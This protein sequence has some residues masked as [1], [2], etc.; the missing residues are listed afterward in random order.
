[1]T[2]NTNDCKTCQAALPD[3]LLEPG[4]RA[5]HR[6]LDAHLATCTAC[7]T[8]LEEMQATFALMDAW[9]APEPTPFFDTRV[10]A[11]LREAMAAEPEGFF[12]RMKARWMYSSNRSFKPALAGALALA[13][14]AVGGG[15]FAG[16][17][18]FGA[19]PATASA[20]VNDLK[21]LDNN[22]QAFQQMDQLLDSGSDDGSNTNDTPT[23]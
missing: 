19:K 21:I 10:K 3:L 2:M 12:A 22:E 1:M 7:R 16:L 9:T 5:K 15:T 13:M 20:A 6:E 17:H 14:I 11:R 23:T 8:E 18:Q 4:Y